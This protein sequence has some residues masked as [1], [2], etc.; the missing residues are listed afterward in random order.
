MTSNIKITK[1]E[2]M[3]IFRIMKFSKTDA[4]VYKCVATNTV[5]TAECQCTVA[6]GGWYN[7]QKLFL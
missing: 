6:V 7:F 4:G 1:E 3:W 5:G 2:N